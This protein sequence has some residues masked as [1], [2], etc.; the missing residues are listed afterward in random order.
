MK[1]QIRLF[2]D[3]GLTEDTP[4][5]E[6]VELQ[7]RA[8]EN[9]AFPFEELSKIAEQESWRKEVN[10]PTYHI[11]K[12]WAQRLGSV[13]RALALGTFS[14]NDANILELFYKP[15]RIG[16]VIV[17]DPFIGS[18]TTLG[19]VLKLGGRVVGQDINPVAHFLVKN[20]LGLPRHE[21][22][23][24]MFK[25]IEADTAE[26]IL[27]MYTA[28]LPGGQTGQVLYYFWVK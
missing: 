1:T 18:G 28:K 2:D 4:H 15:S 22:V 16:D 7:I 10:R 3:Q 21:E 19:E 9:S 25:Q 23:L 8:I 14:P 20:A 6:S 11:H 27:K 24:N 26:R 12:W 5:A 17:F 13:F